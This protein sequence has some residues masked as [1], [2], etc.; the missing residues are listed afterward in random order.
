MEFKKNFKLVSLAAFALLLCPSAPTALLCFAAGVV[1]FVMNTF[2]KIEFIKKSLIDSKKLFIAFF[3]NLLLLAVFIIRW[4]EIINPIVAALLGLVLTII[5]TPALPVIA[6][7]YKDNG[8]GLKVSDKKLS[9]SDHIFFVLFAAVIMLFI[10]SATPLLPIN[11]DYD[12]NCVFTAGRGLIHGKLV[13]RDL[14]DHKGTILHLIYGMGA[15]IT[16]YGF[17]GLW[18]LEI[19]FCYLFMVVTTKI[20]LLFVDSKSLINPVVT[21]AVTIALY[22]SKAFYCGNTAEEYSILFIVLILYFC[23]RFV[24]ENNINFIRTYIVGLCTGV[25]F[26]IKFNLCGA[27]V[28]IVLFMLFYL[29]IKKQTKTLLTAV[30]GVFTGFVTV[31]VPIVL[32]YLFN[33]GISNLVDIYFVMN[34]FKYHMNSQR[35]T[36]VTSLTNPLLAF[37]AHLNDNN[38]LLVLT[39][40]GMFYFYCRNKKLLGLYVTAFIFGSYFAFIGAENCAYY[41]LI[42][43]PFAAIGALPLNMMVTGFISKKS[44][45]IR[46]LGIAATVILAVMFAVPFVANKKYFGVPKEGYPT[47]TFT[48]T[49]MDSED[50]SFVC[51]DFIDCGFYTYMHTDPEVPYYSYLNADTIH[52]INTQRQ[53]IA[54]G[55]YNYIITTNDVD[56]FTGYELVESQQDPFNEE[57]VFY[58]YRKTEA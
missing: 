40:T 45:A 31:A 52:I 51:Y 54:S 37:P 4:A 26:W 2:R 28:G 8:P 56:V 35:G 53:Y 11:W 25:I 32:F 24:A 13:Y 20:Q 6:E 30:L 42:L 41:P 55:N 44:K 29:L 21:G 39:V 22:G 19:I 16:P 49:I 5:A 1:L 10:S 12:T 27:V 47:Y 7:C 17:T 14:I 33:N 48:Q 15:L 34:I 18:I 23:I 46:V 38:Q 58:L 3:L 43:T 9:V 57:K 36:I 50:K